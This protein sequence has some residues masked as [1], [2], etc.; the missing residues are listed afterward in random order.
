MVGPNKPET[1]VYSREH[2][3]LHSVDSVI[4]KEIPGQN[5]S[6]DPKDSCRLPL[7][8][9][10]IL[11]PQCCVNKIIRKL[12][13]DSYTASR[14]DNLSGPIPVLL[15]WKLSIFSP[16]RSAEDSSIQQGSS[17]SVKFSQLNKATLYDCRE[18]LRWT[19][20]NSNR[21]WRHLSPNQMIKV[22]LLPE[23]KPSVT[24]SPR[25]FHEGSSDVNKVNVLRCLPRK[26]ATIVFGYLYDM[27]G[28]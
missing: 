28:K 22:S 15:S 18:L 27:R 25:S 5:S 7:W 12:F 4:E 2:F 10:F 17:Q 13:P 16:L 20:Q 11:R 8:I 6:N 9:V 26:V 19:V 3:L 1:S 24:G 23:A 21:S 14:D